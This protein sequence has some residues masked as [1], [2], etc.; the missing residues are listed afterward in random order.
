MSEA[1]DK[2]GSGKGGVVALALATLVA[3]G[4]GG[5]HGL[6]TYGTIVSAT[7]APASAV[8]APPAAGEPVAGGHQAASAHGAPAK[9]AEKIK[10]PSKIVTKPIQ[11]IVTNIMLPADLWVR[12]E[13]AIVY[14]QADVDDPDMMLTEISGDLLAYLRTLTLR[15]MQGADGLMFV[16][17]DMLERINLRT[18]GKV[19]D[20]IIQTLVVQ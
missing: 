14:D 8:A 10:L 11:P 16:R 3:A 5:A 2:G 6:Q 12:L 7:P 9:P 19:R 18:H 15:E 13:G 17:Q 1:G 4:A 20:I